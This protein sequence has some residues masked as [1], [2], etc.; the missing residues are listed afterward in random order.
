MIIRIVKMTFATDKTD[1]FLQV[2]D[3]SKNKIRNFKGC[4][5]LE[6]L[7]DIHHPNVFFTYSWWESETDLNNYRH[8]ELFKTTWSKTK[9]LFAD[10]PEAWS[11][12]SIENLKNTAL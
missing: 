1:E 6:L 12:K 7:Q 11:L 10:K 2:F 5:H 4:L 9:V 3:T 8:S